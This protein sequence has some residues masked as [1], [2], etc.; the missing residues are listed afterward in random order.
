MAF[1]S[2][3]NF[4]FW[5]HKADVHVPQDKNIYPDPGVLHTWEGWGKAIQQCTQ[6]T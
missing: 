2:A 3:Q 1:L 4:L 6:S 5:G